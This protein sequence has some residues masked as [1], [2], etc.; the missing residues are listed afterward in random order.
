M[1]SQRGRDNDIALSTFTSSG[2]SRS[3]NDIMARGA[4]GANSGWGLGQDSQP[5]SLR[6]FRNQD[7]P[8]EESEA[9]LGEGADGDADDGYAGQYQ[10]SADQN[11]VLT[12]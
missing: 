1:P 7:I 11:F 4:E 2:S 10:V 3:I 6:S 9:L 5:S 8:G 12:V